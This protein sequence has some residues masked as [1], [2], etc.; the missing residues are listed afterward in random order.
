M[1]R[2]IK[3]VDM[4][5][6]ISVLFVLGLFSGCYYDNFEE[7]SPTPP[8]RTDTTTNVNSCDTTNP[9][10]YSDVNV[11]LSANCGINNS[12]HGASNTSGYNLSNYAGVK[13]VGQTGQL[14]GA[15]AQ[16]Q[17][18]IA[19]PQGGGKLSACNIAKV[20]RWI[21]NRYAQ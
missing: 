2:T 6:I 8:V 7:L 15:I 10:L 12:C 3:R 20:K 11:I 21:D 9:T 18:Y 19:M 13:S 16:T 1:L 14:Y 5:K 4:K 17:A